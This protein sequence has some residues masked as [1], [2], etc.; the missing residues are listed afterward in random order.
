MTPWRVALGAVIV[1]AVAIVAWPT[2]HHPT[3]QPRAA[4]RVVIERKVVAPRVYSRSRTSVP[5]LM[6]HV[7]ATPPAG[8]D[9]PGLYVT[10]SELAGQV[11][12]LARAGFHAVTL[13]RMR[14]GW[15]GRA[16]LP[17][18]PIVISFD[19][20][21]RTQ[22]TEA[23]PILRRHGWVADENIQLSG[24]PPSQGGLTRRQVRELVAAGWELDTQGWSHADLPTLDTA[25]LRFQ[26]GAA[27]RR[28]RRAYGVRADWFCYPSRGATTRQ[29]SPRCTRPAS[30]VRRPSCRAGRART[31]VPMSYRGCVCSAVRAR[32]SFLR[33]SAQPGRTRRR[34]RPTRGTRA[35]ARSAPPAGRSRPSAPRPGRRPGRR[36]GS[37]RPGAPR[38]S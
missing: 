33:R 11:D 18:H 19:N 7:I 26:I 9:Y 12:A 2:R 16:E 25:S 36:P 4:H 13:D 14:A 17:A 28:L 21:Y 29:C 24:L 23:L 35:G 34:R 22:Y 15:L 3:P 31:A 8:A 20:G 10:P 30:W 6:Y 27:R 32:R 5:I 38:S 1:A 37:P